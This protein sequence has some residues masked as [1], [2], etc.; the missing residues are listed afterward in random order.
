LSRGRIRRKDPLV[1]LKSFNKL[2]LEFRKKIRQ[3]DRIF[4]ED[5]IYKKRRIF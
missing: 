2:A 1:F 5:S 4:F 3:K